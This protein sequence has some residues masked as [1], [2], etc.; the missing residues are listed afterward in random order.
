MLTAPGSPE[1][2]TEVASLALPSLVEGAAGAGDFEVSN[3][4]RAETRYGF[5]SFHML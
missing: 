4:V 3:E 5:E 1:L 2:S